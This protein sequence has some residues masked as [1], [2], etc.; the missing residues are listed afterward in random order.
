M[1]VGRLVDDGVTQIGV[2]QATV[3]EVDRAQVGS[4]QIGIGEV[5]AAQVRALGIEP[6]EDIRIGEVALGIRVGRARDALVAGIADARA[7]RLVAVVMMMM[8]MLATLGDSIPAQ[9]HGAKQSTDCRSPRAVCRHEPCDCIELFAIHF[10][11]PHSLTTLVSVVT[12]SCAA[13]HSWSLIA[14]GS[15]KPAAASAESGIARW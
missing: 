13:W 5:G 2:D 3:A 7:R 8:M 9:E 1:E 12:N 10:P 14:R 15:R 6:E 11:T 4:R